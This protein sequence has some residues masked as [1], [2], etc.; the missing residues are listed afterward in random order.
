MREIKTP[1]EFLE[2]IDQQERQA[3]VVDFYAHWC[4]PCK[5]LAPLLREMEKDYPNISFAKVDCDNQE[6]EEIQSAN[7]I[8]S[9][10]TICFY[11]QGKYLTRVV[12]N[13]PR[14]IRKIL[15]QIVS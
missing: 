4:G 13:D 15:D 8:E 2:L 12:G 9:L 1:E 3:T 5:A 6:M 7:R 14:Q 11:V 10:P